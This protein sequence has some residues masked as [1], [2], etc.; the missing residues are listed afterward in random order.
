[1]SQ[2]NLQQIV[3]IISTLR[4]TLNMETAIVSKI[5]LKAGR[6]TIQA[7]E[8]VMNVF[9]PNDE[10]ALQDT[11]C[12]AVMDCEDTITYTNVGKIEKMQLHPVYTLLQLESYIGTPIKKDGQAYGTLN[13][14][15]TDIRQQP[16][17]EIELNQV[18]IAAN[19]IAE[20]LD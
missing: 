6:Y 10:F 5:E 17:S 8:S 13:F 16:F 15:S 4:Q 12:A 19:Q 1:M 11:Y 9:K 7:V 2:S 18:K 14:S 3:S 20:L